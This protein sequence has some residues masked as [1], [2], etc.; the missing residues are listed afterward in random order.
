MNA[1]KK[2][3]LMEVCNWLMRMAYINILWMVFTLLGVVVAGFSPATAAA[4]SVCRRWIRSDEEFPVFRVFWQE[5]KQNFA[6][7]QAYGWISIVLMGVLYLDFLYFSSKSSILFFVLTVIAIVL[8]IMLAMAVVYIF[9]VYTHYR[10]NFLQYW[11]YALSIAMVHPLQTIFTMVGAITIGAVLIKLP[12]LLPFF[13]VSAMT[14]WLTWRT[15]KIVIK[16]DE[17]KEAVS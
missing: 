12:S 5:Y 1:L 8:S 6:G 10:L 3:P 15:Q 9:P 4:F 13:G 11:K 16:I 2:M 17:I 14:V 7:S